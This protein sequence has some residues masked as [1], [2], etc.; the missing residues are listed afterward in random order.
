MGVGYRGVGV[1]DRRDHLERVGLASP[2]TV[3]DKLLH[4]HLER[5]YDLADRPSACHRARNSTGE[6]V[7]ARVR[8]SENA[9]ARDRASSS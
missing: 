4:H 3:S 1:M 8:E 2:V 9:R 6:R 5:L 7:C